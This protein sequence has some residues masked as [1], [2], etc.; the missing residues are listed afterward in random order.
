MVWIFFKNMK[1]SVIFINSLMALIGLF[2]FDWNPF[3]LL[4][5]YVFEIFFLSIL[6]LHTLKKFGG[7]N[8]FNKYLPIDTEFYNQQQF[9]RTKK[10]NPMIHFGMG[11]VLFNCIA[12]IFLFSYEIIY[13]PNSQITLSIFISFIGIA[14]NYLINNKKALPLNSE[15]RLVNY[16]SFPIRSVFVMFYGLIVGSLLYSA[17]DFPVFVVIAVILLRLVSDLLIQ[18]YESLEVKKR[19]LLLLG[20]Q[21]K[22]I[23]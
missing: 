9:T 4:L 1:F 17:F 12:V 23:K 7:N 18:K 11:L 6:T 14:I 2:F 19:I 15:A 8:L 21:M 13:L 16:L 20:I 3:G 22:G 10:L 5:I